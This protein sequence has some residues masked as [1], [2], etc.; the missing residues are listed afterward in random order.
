MS[1]NLWE[2]CFDQ[3]KE[4][5]YRHR[6]DLSIDPI[7]GTFEVH[8]V[9]DDRRVRRGGSWA[10][11]ESACRVFTRADSPPNYHGH[12]IGLRVVRTVSDAIP[13][14]RVSTTKVNLIDLIKTRSIYLIAPPTSSRRAWALRI[15][16]LGLTLTTDFHQA[17]L[18]IALSGDKHALSEKLY[19]RALGLGWPV[20]S[21]TEIDPLFKTCL[22][23]TSDAAD[24]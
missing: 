13:K 24:E 20:L 21:E 12:F 3:F 5:S 14:D 17:E 16:S 1:G 4:A 15:V 18:F 7:T 8:T 11:N 9:T 22:L 19:H 10:T 2:W 23:Y 6:S